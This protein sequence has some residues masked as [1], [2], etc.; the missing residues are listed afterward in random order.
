MKSLP[1]EDTLN[2]F[3]RLDFKVWQDQAAVL[4][5]EKIRSYL[6]DS[7]ALD[8]DIRIIRVPRRQVRS[9]SVL[10]ADC[11][12]DKLRAMA[13]MRGEEVSETVLSKADA[14]EDRAAEE[15]LEE[16]SR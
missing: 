6:V 10:E 12:R 9:E 11:L 13:G 3:V 1:L 5:R 2:A 4:D 15:L 8:V 16:I 14:L 7:G